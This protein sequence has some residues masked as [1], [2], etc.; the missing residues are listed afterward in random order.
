MN[1]D[2]AYC[3]HFFNGFDDRLQERQKVE[4]EHFLNY[5]EQQRIDKQLTEQEEDELLNAYR[6]KIEE[7]AYKERRKLRG[8]QRMIDEVRQTEIFAIYNQLNM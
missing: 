2:Y 4:T 1:N 5:V 6:R 3:E 7:E 8:H